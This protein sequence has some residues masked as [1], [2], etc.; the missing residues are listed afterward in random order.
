MSNKLRL[1]LSRFPGLRQTAKTTTTTTTT[2]KTTGNNNN[3]NNNNIVESI[4]KSNGNHIQEE[5]QEVMNN[6]GK[7]NDHHSNEKSIIEIDGIIYL[8]KLISINS[9][10]TRTNTIEMQRDS[11]SIF[12][13]QRLQ[14]PLPSITYALI[15]NVYPDFNVSLA[16]FA[17]IENASNILHGPLVN[18]VNMFVPFFRNFRREEIVDK[19]SKLLQCYSDNRE[20]KVAH[21]AALFNH[22][23]YFLNITIEELEDRNNPDQWSPLHIAVSL[24]NM[25]IVGLMLKSGM[26]VFIVDSNHW[27]VMHFAMLASPQVLSTLL[28][29]S[30]FYQQLRHQ[31]QYGM[32]PM[33]VACFYRNSRH[34]RH[35]MIQ[36]V[37]ARQLT[38]KAPKPSSSKQINLLDW[39]QDY[40]PYVRFDA[41]QIDQD[42][43]W[44]KINLCGS[45][46]HWCQ[47][48]S[49]MNRLIDSRT[50]DVNERD[51]NG[52]TPLMAFVKRLPPIRTKPIRMMNNNNNDTTINDM[53]NQVDG[54]SVI[55]SPSN[56]F[57]TSS[58]LSSTSSS[59]WPM[60]VNFHLS[61]MLRLITAG[62]R[63]NARNY[64]GDTALH[65]SVANGYIIT[66]QLLLIFGARINIRN[67]L[68]QSPLHLAA[69]KLKQ[70]Q[71]LEQNDRRLD[72]KNQSSRMTTTP[73][74]HNRQ[75]Q[76]AANRSS[77]KNNRYIVKQ[78]QIYELI[79]KSLKSIGARTC[80]KNIA[81]CTIDCLHHHHHH[82]KSEEEKKR[83]K[84]KSSS[85]NDDDN[86]NDD[87]KLFHLDIVKKPS[88]QQQKS[89]T[90]DRSHFANIIILDGG[91]N[92]QFM[93][94]LIQI[95]LLNEL[96]QY[97]P[98]S[99]PEYFDIIAGT[100]FGF[101][102]GCSLANGKKL[103]EILNFYLK[104]RSNFR[105]PLIRMQEQN[106]D[107]LEQ[108]L[109]TM[110]N[111][112]KTLADI[113]RQNN[114]HLILTTTVVDDIP[115]R[116]KIVDDQ[117]ENLTMWKACRI[118]GL[119][120][121]LFKTI[122]HEGVPYFDGSL[123]AP[124]PTTDI[125][126]FYHSQILEQQ[127]QKDQTM[128]ENTTNR[129]LPFQLVLSLG[130]GK[131]AYRTNVTPIDLNSF[132]LY[133]PNLRV[134]FNYFRQ[135]RDWFA[136]IL[137]ETDG[138]IVQR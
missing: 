74:T 11:C 51:R 107:R 40:S 64:A 43:D 112:P 89:S 108:T 135:L 3:N 95:I 60:I 84:Q 66:I 118:S 115:V 85:P 101:T 123:I 26:D 63:L 131:I 125:L 94:P 129:M 67:K 81:D 71:A 2:T 44:S 12:E 126:S 14:L 83:K 13:Y 45:P 97:L 104:L 9:L 77:T 132:R 72:D 109:L 34:I 48:W 130:G 76:Q 24:S 61:W 111:D 38:I 37:T 56:Q 54:S 78:K 116:L 122:E 19:I 79:I 47:C 114:K 69:I 70:L 62:A 136:S 113:R 65:F 16:E 128:F 102:T 91:I 33:H 52:D 1:I 134:Y 22:V 100:S 120:A 41:N 49:T 21:F 32:T 127:K 117:I 75:Q 96:Q 6:N 17:T 103:F 82:R 39:Y 124:N 36:G 90:T 73:E 57:S 53:T 46:L 58:L 99:L 106:T 29:M 88:R 30:A 5:M 50:F 10:K 68:N 121:G 110:F 18:L 4:P 31:D 23:D 86:I 27:T 25:Y 8:P 7:E 133:A 20:W 80:P 93:N 105:K 15:V 35:V 28:E 87:Q 92:D 55:T 42:F 119:G 137:M 98:R 59:S 138:H